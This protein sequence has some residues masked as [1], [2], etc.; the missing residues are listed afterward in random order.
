MA[1]GKHRLLP[2]RHKASVVQQEFGKTEI[3]RQYVAEQREAGAHV[4]IT[5][6]GKVEGVNCTDCP[7]VT[8]YE[9]DL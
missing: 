9:G 5:G 4:H 8:P 1:S 2:K 6:V 3:F 7:D